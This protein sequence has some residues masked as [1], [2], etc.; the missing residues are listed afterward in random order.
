MNQTA[1]RG[2][3]PEQLELSGKSWLAQCRSRLHFW[4]RTLSQRMNMR[5]G[6]GR[7]DGTA[8]LLS[9]DRYSDSGLSP[10]TGGGS[11]PASRSERPAMTRLLRDFLRQLS[12]A[13]GPLFGFSVVIN[14]LLL[15]SPLYMLQVYDRVLTSGSADTLLW[16][17]V[18]AVFLML[19]YMAAE[20]GRR[21]VGA[22]A[23]E[24][25]DAAL[26]ARIFRRF[27]GAG[28]SGAQLIADQALLTRMRPLLQS[29][30]IFPILDLPFVPLFLGILFL[31]HP[32]IGSLGLAGALFL[33]AIAIAAE[34]STRR[35]GDVAAADAGK[36]QAEI[37]AMARERA[38][39]LS[40][41]LTDRM[42]QRWFARK[43]NAA[44]GQLDTA[45]RDG[46]YTAVSRAARQVLQVLMLGAG[47]ALAIVQE[48]SP[49]AIVAASIILSRA[50]APVDQIVNSWRSIVAAATAWGQL[51]DGLA[52]VPEETSFLPLPRPEPVLSLER[53]SV[54]VPGSQS[55]LIRPFSLELTKGAGYGLVGQNGAGK[56]SFLETLAG[57]APVGTGSVTLGGRSLH[58]W[59]AADRGRHIGYL[60]QEFAFLPGTIAQNIARFDDADPDEVIAAA[61]LAGVHGAILGLPEGY[62]TQVGPEAHGLSVGQR[63]QIG[64]ARALFR[65]PVL[66]LLD[67]PTAGLDAESTRAVLEAI[68]RCQR[69]GTIVIAATH[70]P[71]LI[72]ALPTVL[73]LRGGAVL[74]AASQTYLESKNPNTE[75]RH[76]GGGG[77]ANIGE[78]RARR[79]SALS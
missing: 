67:E 49:G 57:I 63:R 19:I 47:A 39:I 28:G 48:I 1:P 68:K 3:D 52:D 24:T 45:R 35:A 55:V 40:M 79:E 37:T 2:K 10:A 50:L 51:R 31:I 11:F 26:S 75:E 72:A 46:A 9:T 33:M 64:L 22:L 18:I 70:D 27:E 8:S 23:L 14:L 66:L 61:E 73:L 5:S 12:S 4:W 44:D 21:R 42:F 20:A 65:A 16:L 60:P 77:S 36:A 25:I 78:A 74:T 34:L 38:S 29:Q 15:V 43:E 53:L 62:D 56:T 13:L 17:T 6:S 76:A 59:P 7:S 54:L 30:L 71:A 41:G 69:E 32:A 58:D